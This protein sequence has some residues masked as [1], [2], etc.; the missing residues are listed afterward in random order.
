M[1][2][3]IYPKCSL[4]QLWQEDKKLFAANTETPQPVCAVVSR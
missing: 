4:E 2:A 1:K 3:K